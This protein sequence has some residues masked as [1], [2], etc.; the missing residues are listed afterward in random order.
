[1]IRRLVTTACSLAACAVLVTAQATTPPPAGA[2]QGQQAPT[3]RSRIDSISVDVSV[4]D[5]QGRPVTDLT[6]DD[7]EIREANK[8]QTIDTFRLISADQTD[9]SAI[10]DR[11]ILSLSDHERETADP[12]NRLIVIF[13]DDYHVRKGNAMVIREQLSRWVGQLGPRDLVAVLY[14]LTSISAL[15]FSRNHEGTAMAMMRFEGRKY[16]YNPKNDYE[17]QFDNMPPE[18]VEQA[19]NELVIRALTSACIYVGSMREGRK[20]I[21]YVSE[22]LVATLPAGAR[23][24]G[25]YR[26]ATG[27]DPSTSQSFFA[28]ADL[29]NRMRDIFSAAT[30]NNTSVFTLDPRGLAP[31]EFGVADNVGLDADRLIMNEALD[32]LRTIA[33]QT[34]GRAIVNRNNPMPELLKMVR[35]L[36]AYYLLGYTSTIGARD[37]KFHPIQVRVKRQG[38]EV[39][40]RKGYWAFTEDEVRRASAPPKAGPP[41]DVANA[42]EELASVV[43]PSSHRGV[44]LW[45]GAV[46]GASEKARVTLAWEAAAVPA[47]DPIDRVAR[48][49]LVAIDGGGQE[50][51][52]GP[53]EPDPA[54]GRVAGR[55]SFDAPAGLIKLRLSTENASG[56]RIE[57]EDATYEVPDFTGARPIIS[58][59]VVYRARTARE[60]TLLRAATETLPLPT[61]TRQFSR[62]ERLLVRFDAYGPAGTT[63]KVAVRLLNKMG[64]SLAAFP[65]PTAAS[66]STFDVDVT[67]AALPPGDYLIEISATSATETTKRLL[68]IK[69]T[70]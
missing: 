7:F 64:E 61:I 17:R 15:T 60:I 67:L 66:G 55:V 48:I 4:T 59:P 65:D 56:Q 38:V 28:T 12:E 18:L 19:R 11:Q 10:A 42:L 31:S 16:D 29:M 14:P 22:G 20:T 54:A 49:S 70:G 21:L 41:T 34:D 47:Q 53:V 46:R 1:M 57:N 45:V 25:N 43:E 24:T 33:D 8:A 52:R 37:G 39:R 32:S 27:S 2:G 69:I 62:T 44:S 30:R 3:F 51:F 23:T 35:E 40:H 5:K 13:L 26:P 6:A 63:P 36:S 58:T 68:G 9:V 50:L